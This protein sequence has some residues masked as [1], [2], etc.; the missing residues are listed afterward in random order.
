MTF[1]AALAAV[2]LVGV[3]PPSTP[4]VLGAP[5]AARCDVLAAPSGSD[6]DPGTSER[7]VRSV[8]RVLELLAPDGVGCLRSGHWTEDVTLTKDGTTLRSAP[9]AHATIRGRFWV[10]RQA[11]GV[12]VAGLGLDG[13]SA[14]GLPSPTVN[15]SGATFV[16]DDVTDHHTGICFLLGS[17]GYGRPRGT[18]LARNRIHGCGSLPATNLEHGIY[19]AAAEDTSIIDNIIYDNADRG[20]QLYPD[21][22]RTRIRGNIIYGNG[23]GVIFSGAGGVASSRN[24]VVGN[25]IADSRQ[26]ADV[27]SYYPRG[28]PRGT[29]NVV[30]GNCV[31]GGRN[32]TIDRSA[33]GFTSFDNVEAE[34]GF[35]APG[36]AD[37]RLRAGSPCAGVLAASRAP[38]GPHGEQPLAP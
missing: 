10:T 19:V 34:P 38:A 22:T 6:R 20:V 2:A 21:A 13:R 8:H 33:G 32:G 9:G 29:A 7:P 12:R 14:S 37:F 30:R 15:G 23:V 1:A 36:R 35:L 31:F 5:E 4:A 17:P 16:G 25:V 27:E 24:A 28:T 11:T 26:R 18:T 3:G